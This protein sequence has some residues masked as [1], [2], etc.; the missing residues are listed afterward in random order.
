[1]PA[2]V[3]KPRTKDLARR[4]ADRRSAAVIAEEIRRLGSHWRPHGLRNG[5]PR[6]R[7]GQHP[8]PKAAF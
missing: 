5:S 4:A 6:R 1:M 8:G 7:G 2:P 3:T